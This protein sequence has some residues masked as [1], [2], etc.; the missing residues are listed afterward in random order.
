M[1]NIRQKTFLFLVSSMI[2]LS[3][4]ALGNTVFTKAE[5]PRM[6]LFPIRFLDR[7]EDEGR[8]QFWEA[9]KG[10]QVSGESVHAGSCAWAQ[11]PA[12]RYNPSQPSVLT[13]DG[14]LDLRQSQKPAA[15]WWNRYKLADGDTA[16]MQV[17]VTGGKDWTT[18]TELDGAS[19]AWV[20]Q[21]VN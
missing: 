13:L 12:K 11:L 18:M 4:V 17:R 20:Q 16:L 5:T 14:A 2:L 19:E 9:S 3:V 8:F 10:W 7:V 15:T 6:R 1:Y 21:S